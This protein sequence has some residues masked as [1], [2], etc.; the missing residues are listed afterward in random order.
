[1]TGPIDA[2]VARRALAALPDGTS[3]GGESR[4]EHVYLPPSHAR[5]LDPDSMLV[6]GMR[7]AGKTFWWSALQDAN[8]RR[9]VS[10]RISTSG[11]SEKTEVL[12]GFGVTPGSHVTPA[13]DKYPG[14]D[15][16]ARLMREGVAPRLVWRTVQ[17]WQLA[18]ED[19]PLRTRTSWKDRA[20]FVDGDPEAI[21]R[22]F[23]ER[24]AALDRKGVHLLILFDALDRCADEWK[25]MYRTIRGLLQTALD[26]RS[27]RRLRVK[28]F[29]RSDQVA[30]TEIA[31][32]PDASK[33]LSSAVE[34][35]WPRREL[36]G[37]LWHYLVNGEQG[38]DFR[39]F[40]GG[41]DWPS[42][43]VGDNAVFSVPRALVS[44][45]DHQR[46][47]FHALAGKW[48]GRGPKRGFPYTWIPNHLGDTEGRVSPRSFLAALR[49]A[50]HDTGSRNPEC[51][52]ALHYD[53]IKSGVQEASKIRV[54]EIREDY[55][56]MDRV[57]RPLEGLVVPCRFDEIAE[58]WSGVLE[59]LTEAVGQEDVKL[60][61]AHIGDG[62]EG[63]RDDLETLGVFLRLRDGRV[64]VPDVFRVGYGIGRRGGVKPVR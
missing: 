13:R 22:L 34:L 61:P 58:R 47:K 44:G 28:V 51:A 9:L 30:E 33:V 27:Y 4:P 16:L 25:D 26:V 24:D 15:V 7:G 31:D 32:F 5:A 6:T 53:G 19:H 35:N 3:H 56:W 21:E 60:P 8:V 43:D 49:T 39:R 11:L 23:Q 45:D 59:R 63:V 17:A 29:L 46:E 10:S 18:E 62:P 41:G 50:A 37:L 42:V 40:F 1:M 57:L 2:G 64:N 36:Y 54:R 55:P 38:R 12:T 20:T 52:T 14:K 48:M